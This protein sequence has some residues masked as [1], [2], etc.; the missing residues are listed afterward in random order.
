MAVFIPAI[1][2]R[3][4]LPSTKKELIMEEL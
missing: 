4:M 1:L 2:V 3:I